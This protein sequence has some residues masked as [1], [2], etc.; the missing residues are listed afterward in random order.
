MTVRPGAGIPLERD[1]VHSVAEAE[2]GTY[3]LSRRVRTRVR[4]E[5]PTEREEEL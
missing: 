2:L 3:R 4:I 1:T 5:R